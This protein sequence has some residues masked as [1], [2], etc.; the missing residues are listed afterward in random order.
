MLKI[1][2]PTEGTTRDETLQRTANELEKD[3]YPGLAASVREAALLPPEPRENGEV[4]YKSYVAMHYDA[5]H[6]ANMTKAPY[7][8]VDEILSYDVVKDEP[9]FR[10]LSRP[11]A[12]MEYAA[13]HARLSGLL[14]GGE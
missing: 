8:R 5:I 14:Q 1:A 13:M 2:D 10:D 11:I 4:A 7:S 12:D 6:A 9:E 3:G